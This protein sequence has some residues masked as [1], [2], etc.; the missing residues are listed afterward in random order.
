LTEA[1]GAGYILRRRQW[2][3]ILKE[4]ENNRSVQL[5]KNLGLKA[6]EG[7]GEGE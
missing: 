4:T 6:R 7:E 3:S 1:A 5:G 2:I